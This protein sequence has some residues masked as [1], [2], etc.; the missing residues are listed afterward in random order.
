[1]DKLFISHASEDKAFVV[2]LI[3]HLEA[4]RIDYWFDRHEINSGDSL[5]EKINDGLRTS[6]HGV[7]ILSPDY[8][9]EDKVWTWEELWSLI[10]IES[11]SKKRI[12]IPIRLGLSHSEL[13]Q[14]APLIAHRLSSDFIGRPQ[15][16]AQEIA[17]VL[18]KSNQ[19]V[20][21]LSGEDTPEQGLPSQHNIP[22]PRPPEGGF[23]GRESFINSIIDQLRNG[24]GYDSSEFGVVVLSGIPGFG[25]STIACELAYRIGRQFSGGVFW[26][27]ARTLSTLR[28]CVNEV[29]E[30][31]STTSVSSDNANDDQDLYT[32]IRR[33]L[34]SQSCL[35]IFDAF[36]FDTV[37]SDLMQLMPKT[38]FSRVLITTRTER[39]DLPIKTIHLHVPEL[40]LLSASE[41]LMQFRTHSKSDTELKIIAGICRELGFL[42]L[43]LQLAARYLRGHSISLSDYLERLCARGPSWKGLASTIQTIP[44]VI[45]VL[46]QSVED[47]KEHGEVGKLALKIL[48]RCAAIELVQGAIYRWDGEDV[49]FGRL[50]LGLA[51]SVGVS[52]DDE[53]AVDQFDEA[54]NILERIGLIRLSQDSSQAVWLHTLTLQFAKDFLDAE[55][56][57]YL[58]F[59]LHIE[60]VNTQRMMSMAG[61]VN[62]FQEMYQPANTVL[63][64]LKK[65]SPEA[66]LDALRT[67]YAMA[68]FSDQP[69][70]ESIV[71]EAITYLDT[72]DKSSAN[73]I[74][75]IKLRISKAYCVYKAKR[76][77]E[78]ESLYQQ[79]SK[80]LE[81]IGTHTDYF[82][83]YLYYFGCLL[84][85]LGSDEK[86]ARASKLWDKAIE[87][88]IDELASMEQEKTIR[89]LIFEMKLRLLRLFQAKL[90]LFP[91]LVLDTV[92]AE[93]AHSLLNELE[94]QLGTP[95]SWDRQFLSTR[96]PLRIEMGF[97]VVRRIPI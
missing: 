63:P 27:N 50:P 56:A 46:Q 71:D 75:R 18:R 39:L 34:E 29:A 7:L 42:P 89:Y 40:D 16:A 57:K 13:T 24:R 32:V 11:T 73:A 70:A 14:S 52:Q 77:S 86:R 12:L 92:H 15:D 43:A 33:Y 17:L 20:R 44:S 5:P 67:F 88:L 84:L 87:M 30:L 81:T 95:V 19:T 8:L 97:R 25:K 9:R 22:M 10:N 82:A 2:Q 96:G 31:L 49:L 28:S 54:I 59:R 74:V 6:T 21:L 79:L 72:L 3:G 94:P 36:D 55:D 68:D 76:L 85:D 83:D 26:F 53:D 48:H 61:W 23:V 58:A 93:M 37:M 1:M 60:W 62:Y 80:D 4:S 47:I 78:A 51:A 69:E 90:E 35:I 66:A 91:E 65:L 41:V 38:G 64:I 45:E